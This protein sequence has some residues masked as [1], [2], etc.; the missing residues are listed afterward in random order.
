MNRNLF[1][2]CSTRSSKILGIL[3]CIFSFQTWN[4]QAQNSVESSQQVQQQ[5]RSFY[6]PLIPALD[7]GYHNIQF[8]LAYVSKTKTSSRVTPSSG[9]VA[10]DFYLIRTMPT[11]WDNEGTFASLKKLIDEQRSQNVIPSI[12]HV[13]RPENSF[14]VV[15]ERQGRVLRPI[16]NDEDDDNVAY[17][18]DSHY[19]ILP[20]WN[21]D[22]FMNYAQFMTTDEV[23]FFEFT[24]R[25]RESDGMV[26]KTLFFHPNWL[27]SRYDELIFEADFDAQTGVCLGSR[28]YEFDS[29]SPIFHNVAIKYEASP[30]ED[31]LPVPSSIET[32]RSGAFFQQVVFVDYKSV[33]GIDDQTFSV[34]RFGFS[35]DEFIS[36]SSKLKG[37]LIV[38]ALVVVCLLVTLLALILFVH[39]LTRSHRT[40]K[41]VDS[42]LDDSAV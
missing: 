3:F 31:R 32:N 10:K 15:N 8:S 16:K 42:S 34:E 36:A 14:A 11:L 13:K 21:V 27:E 22:L 20:T 19:G 1:N 39:L 23:T 6:E 38:A 5:F 24:D 12:V 30:F 33:D 28:G 29:E 18:V 4:L 37:I 9:I 7:K 25:R 41:L 40:R 2:R 17:I 26:V 35:E